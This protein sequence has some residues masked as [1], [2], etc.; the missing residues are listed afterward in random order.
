[1]PRPGVIKFHHGPVLPDKK[2]AAQTHQELRLAFMVLALPGEQNG[3]STTWGGGG[4]G[5]QQAHMV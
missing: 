3:D 5:V 4:E 2:I 1:M